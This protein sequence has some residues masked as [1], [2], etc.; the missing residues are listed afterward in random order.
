MRRSRNQTKVTKVREFPIKKFWYGKGAA[1]R[2]IDELMEKNSK[3]FIWAVETF[4]DLTPAQAEH[5]KEVYGMDLPSEVICKQELLDE[6]NNG[7][8]YEFKKGDTEDIYKEMCRK[9]A[10]AT[11]QKWD[12]WLLAGYDVGEWKVK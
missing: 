6:I 3:W 7:E 2:D 4:Q 11:G 12:A 5:F 1:Y 8:P 10:D 9:Y